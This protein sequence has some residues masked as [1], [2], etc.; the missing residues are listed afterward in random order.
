[1]TAFVRD[2][3]W[4]TQERVRRIAI[5]NAVGGAAMLLFLLVTARDTIDIFGRPL[6]TDFS[7]FWNAGHLANEGRAASA[8]S[9]AVLNAAAHRFH[10]GDV[11]DSAWLYPPVFMLVA[12]LLAMLPYVWAL[13]LWQ[14]LSVAVLAAAL[15]LIVRDRLAVLI[16]LASPLTPLVLAHGQNAFLTAALLG[17]GLVLIERRPGIAGSLLGALVYK[18]QLGLMIAPLLIFTRS[19]RT[20]AAG[21]LTVTILCALSY[22]LWGT[23]AWHAFFASLHLGRSFMEVGAVGFYKSASLFAMARQWGAPVALG[24]VIQAVG[25]LGGIALIWRLR[26]AEADIRA[27]GTCAALALSTPYLLDYD[28][29]ITGVG[30]VFLYAC[31][32]R[33]RVLDYERTALA[34]IWAAPWFAR[35]AAQYL[36][37]PLGPLAM[38]LLAGLA[39]RRAG[40]TA[41]PSRRLHEA[42]AQ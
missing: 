37:L 1:M 18:P 40:I 20:I 28:M 17:G 8:W 3:G 42:S 38:L 39:L 22:A 35:P 4:L 14:L 27:A 6:G 41:S 10:G 7:V 15:A 19:W 21:A 26:S 29:A 32:A 5:I 25:A 24:Y 34:F 11:G 9:P 12:S 31:A 36:T 2:G 13:I 33:S 30:A 16:C 23:A